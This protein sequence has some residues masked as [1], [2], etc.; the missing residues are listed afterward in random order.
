MRRLVAS[1]LLWGAAAAQDAPSAEPSEPLMPSDVAASAARH[2]PEVVSALADRDGAAGAL[3]G[4][5]GAFDTVFSVDARS[6]VAGFYDGQVAEAKAE[7]YFAPDSPLAGAR[8][9]GGYRLS[10]G[11]FPIYENEAFTNEG[12]ELKVGILFSLLRDRLIDARRFGILDAELSLRQAD[13]EVALTRIGVQRR[14]LLSYYEW[15]EAGRELDVFRDLLDLSETRQT[16]FERQVERGARAAIF[17]TE[18]G[19]NLTRRRILVERAERDLAL[20]ANALSLYYRGP[21]GEPLVPGPAR[22]PAV[23]PLPPPIG[24]AALPDILSR[25]PE[26]AVLRTA[27]ERARARLDLAENAL[28]PRLDLGAEVGQDFGAIGEG[29]PTFDE[30]EVILGLNFEMPLGNR[31]ARGQRAE[32]RA[33]AR[34]IEADRRLLADRIEAE[35]RDVL[36]ALETAE[37]LVALARLEAEQ[38]EA[39]RAAEQRRFEAGASDFFLVNLREEAV[40]DA[41]I[42]LAMA[43]LEL[44]AARTTYDAAVMDTGRLGLGPGL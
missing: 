44:N 29:G 36:I 15:V 16:A 24:D 35:L 40:A 39:M 34:R 7:R 43:L 30:G 12:G 6:R 11:D 10:R 18:N 14:A 22:L 5:R 28:R 8:L 33:D 20:A 1:I 25:R 23:V 13:L 27:A 42:K 21:G 19:Q 3:L 9:Y 4:A 32:A 17:L 38:A 2:Y 31:A 41:R 37:R 26:L